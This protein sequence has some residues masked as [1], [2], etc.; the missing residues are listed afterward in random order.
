[1][2]LRHL[3]GVLGSVGDK[4]V[5]NGEEF[6]EEGLKDENEKRDGVA[7]ALPRFR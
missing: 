5:P 7:P 1:M 6:G 4:V 2:Y 3:R